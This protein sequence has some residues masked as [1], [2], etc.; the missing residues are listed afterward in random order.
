MIVK[1]CGITNLED[2]LAA[3]EGGA[4]ALGFNF[5]PRSPRYIA[6][7]RAAEIGAALP[8]GV[9]KAGVFVNEPRAPEIARLAALD[10]VQLHGDELPDDYPAGFRVWKAA[11][12]EAGFDLSAWD[13]CPAEALLLDGPAGML[14][15]GAG[16]SFDWRLAHGGKKIVLAGGLDAS[17]VRPAIEQA[18]PWGVDACSR[19]ESAPG[20]KDRRKMAAFLKAALETI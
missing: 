6:P 20:K 9:W 4:A 12:V 13:G 7:E 19:L 3:V 16:A 2:A 10:I 17:N 1:I 11:R 15:G 18:R 8:A 5:W 14:Y